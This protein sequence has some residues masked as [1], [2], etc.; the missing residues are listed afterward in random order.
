[1]STPTL[2]KADTKNPT[3]TTDIDDDERIMTAA[4]RVGRRVPNMTVRDLDET[5]ILAMAPALVCDRV[6]WDTVE[7]FD[8]RAILP[9]MS[10]WARS[11]QW[12]DGQHRIWVNAGEGYDA[13]EEIRTW[14]EEH[15]VE[16]VNIR[17]EP[18]VPFRDVD[19]IPN[20][21]FPDLVAATVDWLY[22]RTYAVR[23]KLVADL[24]LVEDDDLRSMM[25]LFV[26]DIA[27]R[28]DADRI[29]RNGTLNFAAFALGKMRKWP[30]DMARQ[31][32]GR[33][34]IDDRMAIHRAVDAMA[35]E[36]HRRP[37]ESELAAS[38]KLSVGDLRRRE[39]AIASLSSI[40]NY[41]PLFSSDRDEALDVA[42]DVVVSDEATSYQSDAALTRAVV[43]AAAHPSA[44]SRQR[45]SDPLALAAIY[46]S[47]WAGLT[48]QQVA[49][50]L[51]VLPKT[52]AAAMARALDQAGDEL[53]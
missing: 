47:F 40:R 7:D 9:D 18:G 13:R 39:Q 28:Y 15:Q 42:D 44:G 35:A 24:E 48:R 4:N 41:Q 33:V 17:V 45:A 46:L 32:Y 30:Q 43:A 37:T 2:T 50:E 34:A 29:G 6:H 11:R 12:S 38:L 52:A 14:C 49:I 53:R 5:D 8:A 26:S 3:T 25:Y 31:A 16:A 36:Q 10:R 21:L 23:R 19:S 51:Q 27:D 22:P 1:M 20:G